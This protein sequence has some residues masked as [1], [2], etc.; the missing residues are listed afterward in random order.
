MDRKR[1]PNS[2]PLH[3]QGSTTD[4]GEGQ[5]KQGRLDAA[6]DRSVAGVA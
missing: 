2:V 1:A 6:P 4:G 3:T 5:A